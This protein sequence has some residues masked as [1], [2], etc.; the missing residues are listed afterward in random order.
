MSLP[1]LRR[2]RDFMLLQ[3][4][5]LLSDA[6][7]QATT[8]AYPLLALAITGSAA[9]AGLVSF[10]RLVPSALFS[11]PAG[12]AADRHDRRRLM[13]GA[14]AVRGVAMAG[15]AA[16]IVTG[17]VEFWQLPLVA[18]VEG[19]GTAVFY[20][21]Q[22]GALRAVVPV[23]Q[24]PAAFGVREARSAVVRLLGPLAGGA[25][26]GVAR[27]APF[28]AD[29]ASY[30]CSTASLIAMRTPFQQRGERS[31]DGALARLAEGF[32]F[33]WGRP[34]L[35]DCAF[36]Y[37]LGNFAL[38]G[39]FLVIVVVGQDQGLSS[40]RIGALFTVFGICTLIGSVASPLFRRH[41]SMR[42]IVWI[43]LW[44]WLGTAAFLIWPNV[45]VLLAGILPQ[46][47]AMPVT[48]SVVVGYRVAVTPDRLIG[49]VESVRATISLAIAPL[50][51]LVA[52]LL[53]ESVSPRETVAFF[54]GVSA[55]LLAWGMLSPAI[56]RAPTLAELGTA[57]G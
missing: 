57:V 45:Y 10:A 51:P 39:V 55:L 22:P 7:S 48:D 33:L 56:R 50:G 25:L 15:L 5:Q 31:A 34:F 42:T 2:N 4:G 14:D 35:R 54:T 29:A 47:V 37:G 40:A 49:R 18:F 3:A 27:A 13:I 30:I 32:R 52:G 36:I 41:C 9:K 8:I 17:S 19:T 20:A 44:T 38:P 26:F 46:A 1:P 6:G 16:A 11:L 23:P 24:L 12:L 43:E 28:I 21:A 53:L